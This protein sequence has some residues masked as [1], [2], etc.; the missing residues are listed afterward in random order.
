MTES[1]LAFL[2]MHLG[3]RLAMGERGAP[4]RRGREMLNGGSAA[5]RLYRTQDG[6]YLSVGAIEPQ[7]L[8]GLLEKL[9]RP[10]LLPKMHDPQESALAGRALEAVFASKPLAHW[11]QL[12]EGADLCVEPV[13][14]GDDVL[15][16]AQLRAR[17][18]FVEHSGRT[19]L[20]TPLRWGP[21]R[22]ERP[23]RLGEHTA[24]VLREAGFTPDEI[25]ALSPEA[26]V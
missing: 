24:E 17:G 11:L 25:A 19:E 13:A 15:A 26:A 22:L 5:Y 10:E 9:G 2:H 16:D 3:A 8:E 4:L 14:E 1:A 23:P 7:F 20:R 12:F 18:V 21:P 6:R